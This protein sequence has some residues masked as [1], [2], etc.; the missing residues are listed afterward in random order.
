[1]FADLGRAILASDH[2]SFP[3]AV[4]EPQVVL[5]EFTRRRMATMAE[6]TLD[7]PTGA[8]DFL[9]QDLAVLQGSDWAAYDFAHQ[10][11]PL[12]GAPE[13]APL[14]VRPRLDVTRLYHHRDGPVR[15]REL[16]FR[17]SW[18]RFEQNPVRLGLPV[19][20]QVTVG[21]TLAVDWET[22]RIRARLPSIAALGDEQS[23]AERSAQLRDWVAAGGLRIGGAAALDDGASARVEINGDM[24]RV[25]DSLR[26]IDIAGRR[27]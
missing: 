22:R 7:D 26:T 4:T 14:R 17:V 5:E 23:T 11:R 3:D 12:F 6:L 2:A 20:R 1:M 10:H 18:D 25:R 8:G 16:L 9:D 21:T 15:V 24:M 13:S 27:A 19:A